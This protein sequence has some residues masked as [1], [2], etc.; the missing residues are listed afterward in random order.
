MSMGDSLAGGKKMK[1][2]AVRMNFQGDDKR[3]GTGLTGLGITLISNHSCVNSSL[4]QLCDIH[5]IKTDYI[6]ASKLRL[7]LPLKLK[8]RAQRRKNRS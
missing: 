5:C 1:K 7:T 4:T 2:K 3:S 8:C 6:S